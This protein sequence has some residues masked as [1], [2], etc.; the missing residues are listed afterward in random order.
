MDV[1]P[2]RP[3]RSLG[4]SKV[5][6]SSQPGAPH[7]I[8]GPA[9]MPPPPP[10]PD[11]APRVRPAQKANLQPQQGRPLTNQ[12]PQ[13]E[14]LPP[15]R[16]R[17]AQA[18][19][20]ADLVQGPR[21]QQELPRTNRSR[22]RKHMRRALPARRADPRLKPGLKQRP[23][24]TQRTLHPIRIPRLFPALRAD[25][26]PQQELNRSQPP[27]P[28]LRA[29]RGPRASRERNR[30]LRPRTNQGQRHSTPHRLLRSISRSPPRPSTA[31]SRPRNMSLLRT[32]KSLQRTS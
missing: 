8:E 27:L 1:R 9:V 16:I 14:R 12:S 30:R 25:R 19:L 26:K 5:P 17:Q 15:K 7:P 20:R 24:L 28:E 23:L 29:H 22:Q 21:P 31:Q 13:P 3:L 32:R 2:S 4:H 10:Q 18:A 11:L 6:A